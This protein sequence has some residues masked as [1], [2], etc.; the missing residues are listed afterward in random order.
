[1]WLRCASGPRSRC[2]EAISIS[3]N[4]AFERAAELG[5]RPRR[6]AVADLSFLAL[7]SRPTW[8]A[9]DQSC[10]TFRSVAVWRSVSWS[11]LTICH[12]FRTCTTEVMGVFSYGRLQVWLEHHSS[13]NG[14]VWSRF[15]RSSNGNLET[16]K[17]P[18]YDVSW[19]VPARTLDTRG[20]Q[21]HSSPK[22]TQQKRVQQNTTELEQVRRP[23]WCL[24]MPRLLKRSIICCA[25][26]S[27][28]VR[29]SPTITHELCIS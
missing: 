11:G 14:H 24:E 27:S 7:T 28:F 22:N 10:G 25:E 9:C 21:R 13:T 19:I 6:A 17:C 23:R 20:F 5:L 15:G 8:C 26:F 1:M 29:S 3:R 4:S 18:S 12:Q 16:K 2:V